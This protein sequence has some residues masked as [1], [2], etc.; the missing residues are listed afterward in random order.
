MPICFLITRE[1]ENLKFGGNL[2]SSSSST[3]GE[4]LFNN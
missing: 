1:G 3:I 4:Q 2:G